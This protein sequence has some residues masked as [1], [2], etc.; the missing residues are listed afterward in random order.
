[1]SASHGAVASPF[2]QP[3]AVWAVAFAC[4]ISFMGIG[5]VDPILPALAEELD[6][7][8]SQV[9]LLFTSYLVVTAVAMLLVGWVSS[10]IG[11]K[12]TLVVGLAVIVVFAALA[13]ASGSID[14]IV[15]FRA[16]WGL[17]NALFIATSLAVIVASASGGFAGAIIL[18]E[19]ALGLG[20]AVGPLLGGLLGDL[21]WRGPF[22]GVAALMAIA[23][24]ATAVFV[25]T[26]PVPARRTPLSAPL[27]ALR[28]RGLLTMALVAVLY[29]WGFFTMLGYA[30]YPM[31]LHAREL[32]YV[33]FGWGLLVAL[34]SVF[35]AP[36]LQARFGTAPVLYANLAGCAAVM[37]VIGF[38]VD[39]P[40]A[41]IAAVVVSGA[42]IGINNTL[43]TQAVM[44]VAPV[45]RSVASSAYGFVRFIGGG[46]AP[47]AAGELADATDLS[48]PF[49]L[50]AATFLL[51]VP[52][53]ATGHRLIAAA[54][55]GDDGG[56][57]VGPALEPVGGSAGPGAVI[58]A[59]G[60]GEGAASVVDA[61]AAVARGTG[62]AL[63]V[64][65][66]RETAVIEEQAIEPEDAESARAAVRRHLDRL[67]AAGI[68]ATGQVLTSV[69][70]HAAAGRA[71]ARHA[72]DAGA[73]A[74]ALGRSGRGPLVQF[75]EG[76][77]TAAVA[78]EATCDVLLVD[79]ADAPRPLTEDSLESLRTALS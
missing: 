31:E 6:A 74:V 48:M 4:V 30:P 21:S 72:A 73:R 39:T 70:D 63:E 2:R 25:P 78:R 49:F 41:V 76:G 19:T 16:G 43:T 27:K 32:G 77:F 7:T 64:V 36:R 52:V 79:P 22:F 8:P 9:S 13:G 75:A 20:I 56:E 46:L 61:A 62:A 34:F 59:V 17:G 10:R 5:L 15:G 3:R 24:I 29:N 55:R 33:F 45:E 40:A 58:V 23:L 51:A 42:F 11:A 66:V 69:G 1:M 18:Y 60:A 28:H 50:G 12:R 65:H 53:L 35:V 37:A 57:P 38:G 26:T 71:L 67:S 14:G 47:W 54:E 44:L 68:A